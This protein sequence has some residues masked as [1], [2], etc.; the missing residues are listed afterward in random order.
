MNIQFSFHLYKYLKLLKAV[1]DLLKRML[2]INHKVL[3]CIMTGEWLHYKNESYTALVMHSKFWTFGSWLLII[4]G[5][6]AHPK[7]CSLLVC[8]ILVLRILFDVSY[9][10]LLIYRFLI[11]LVVSFFFVTYW[12]NWLICFVVAH[13]L[14]F[15]DCIPA[16]YFDPLLI[17][18]VSWKLIFYLEAWGGVAV[19]CSQEAVCLLFFMCWR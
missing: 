12:R 6:L 13:S 15:A 18:C 3:L 11:H 5:S 8:N 19:F 4:F 14:A 2:H 16:V 9:K 7:H 17:L 1:A 10:S